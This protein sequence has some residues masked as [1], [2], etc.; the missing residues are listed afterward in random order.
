MI[1]V[2]KILAEVDG[3][4]IGQAI[5]GVKAVKVWEGCACPQILARWRF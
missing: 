5:P 1:S 4:T 3:V 2:G